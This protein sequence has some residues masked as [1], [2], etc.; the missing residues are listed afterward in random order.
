MIR[1]VV[2]APLYNGLSETTAR[3]LKKY[4]RTCAFKPRN[5]LDQQL[6]RLKDN[7][8]SMTIADVIYKVQHNES[9]VLTLERPPDHWTLG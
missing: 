1:Q 7:V 3:L 4:R 8:D 6:F 5:T 2:S 9:L